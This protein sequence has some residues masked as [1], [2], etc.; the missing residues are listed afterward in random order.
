[1]AAPDELSD[2]LGAL[3]PGDGRVRFC[4]TELEDLQPGNWVELDG[5]EGSEP[6]RIVFGLG[7]VEYP[8]APPDLPRIHRLLTPDEI[9]GLDAPEQPEGSPT[10]RFGSLGRLRPLMT[11]L[12]KHIRVRL[13]LDPPGALP[14]SPELPHLGAIVQTAHGPGVL[15]SVSMR[16]QSATVRLES[17]EEIRVPVEDLG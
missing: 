10:V 13:G 8:D 2:I 9:A 1:M 11:D 4:R 6:A 16:H 14:V 5:T 3:V 15:L 7:Q 12:D 17:G